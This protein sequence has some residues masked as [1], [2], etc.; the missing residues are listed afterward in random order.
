MK[1]GTLLIISTIVFTI[2]IWISGLSVNTQISLNLLARMYG[3]IGIVLLCWNYILSTRFKILEEL[4]DG[5]D[6]LYSVHHWIGKW[7]FLLI[8]S[9]PILLILN[10]L[11]IG[12][13]INQYIIPTSNASY[14]FGVLGLY[15][16][17]ILLFVT[18]VIK[19][20][21]HLW[22]L[23]H[24]F[25]GI[26][27]FILFLHVV[28]ISSDTSRNLILR[29]WI[30]GF[31][32]IA[33]ISYVY[34]RFIYERLNK[35]IYIIKDIKEIENQTI[36]MNLE[37]LKG[38]VKYSHGHFVFIKREKGNNSDELHPFSVMKHD[39]NGNITFG[40]KKS[41]DYTETLNT[42]QV[43]ETVYL[44]GPYGRFGN[45]FDPNGKEVWIAGGI[46]I[47]PFL[48]VL[49]EY[50]KNSVS[51]KSHLIYTTSS[52]NKPPFLSDLEKYSQQIPGFTYEIWDNKEKGWFTPSNYISDDVSKYLICASERATKEYIKILK[53]SG[54]NS[55]KIAKELFKL[56]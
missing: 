45:K 32:L 39:E 49:D 19:L 43:G 31:I 28:L 56:Y 17:I 5:L 15:L 9:H 22:K 33:I 54:V 44:Y 1:K 4:F 30:L 52:G 14:S 23:T 27:L 7:G 13:N 35:L 51:I 8:L 40:I 18:L 36:L 21:Y 46:G 38:K 53:S 6:N 25:M 16:L 47:T 3:L 48:S 42:W 29:Y 37:I 34:K 50:R 55:S 24:D 11:D 41:G 12:I 10:G 20:P 26:P 2:I